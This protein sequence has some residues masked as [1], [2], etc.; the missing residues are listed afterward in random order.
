ML[1]EIIAS[2]SANLYTYVIIILLIVGGIYFTIR[3]KAV[4]V[5]TIKKQDSKYYSYNWV[6][7]YA[8]VDRNNIDAFND[9]S[10][11]IVGYYILFLI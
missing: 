8:T 9:G 2:I 6:Y 5:R 10:G 1:A 11:F 7:S 4:Q 3:T